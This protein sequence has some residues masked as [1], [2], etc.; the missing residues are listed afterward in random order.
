MRE[1]VVRLFP[2]CVIH[3]AVN[4]VCRPT[5]SDILALPAWRVECLQIIDVITRRDIYAIALFNR[6]FVLR[7]LWSPHFSVSSSKAA[8]ILTPVSASKL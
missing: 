2:F 8:P 6:D 4:G 5:V 1:S 7:R 3:L